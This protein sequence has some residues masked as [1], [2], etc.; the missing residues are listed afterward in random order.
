MSAKED[1]STP[2]PEP[3]PVPVTLMLRPLKA[4]P[5]SVGKEGGLAFQACDT[6]TLSLEGCTDLLAGTIGLESPLSL[7][8]CGTACELSAAGLRRG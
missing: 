4:K 5:R 2:A 3:L 1:V 6:A 8:C 7:L